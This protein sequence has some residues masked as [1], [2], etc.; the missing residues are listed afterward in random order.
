MKLRVTGIEEVAPRVKRFTLSSDHGHLP[1]FSPGSHLRVRLPVGRGIT[2]AYSLTSSPGESR[3]YQ[4]AVYR[5]EAFR[6]GS[7]Y[8]HESV[9]ENDLLDAAAPA[10]FFPLIRT[11]RRHLLL[12]GGIGITPFL[13]AVE[14]LRRWQV[15]FELHYAFRGDGAFARELRSDPSVT[16]YDTTRSARPDI[17]HLLAAQPIGTHVYVCGPAGMVETV[18]TLAREI[19]LPD[20]QVHA[21]RFA[22]PA[23]GVMEAFPVRLARSGREIPVGPDCSLLEA[24]ERAGVDVPHACRVG[25]CGT[26]EV[27]VVSGVIDH[28]DHCLGTDERAHGRKL[29]A[30]VSRGRGPLVLDL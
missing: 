26:C 10:N 30:C 25:G 19:G 22:P 9:R 1:P 15:P 27:P 14:T 16:L 28:R 3:W 29:L 8:L 11:A 2:N 20:E 23:S 24:L 12:A 13:P 18:L 4:I 7:A 17:G 5:H 6:G 21:E